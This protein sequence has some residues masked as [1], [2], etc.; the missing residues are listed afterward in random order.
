MKRIGAARAKD[1]SAGLHAATLCSDLELPWGSAAGVAERRRLLDRRIRSLPASAV[2]PF[3]RATAAGNGFVK[4]CLYWPARSRS[5][6]SRRAQPSS[7]A[8]ASPRG[9]PRPV[10]AAR[11]GTRGGAACATR[12]ARRGGRCGARSAEPCAERCRAPGGRGVP[13]RRHD[14]LSGPGRAL[15]GGRPGRTI[16]AMRGQMMDF[17][18]TLPHLLWRAETYWGDK[19]IVTRLPDKSFHRYTYRDMARRARQLGGCAPGAR[20]RTRRPRGDAVLEPPPAHGV[21]LRNPVRGLRAPHPQ[22]PPASERPRLHRE[23]RGRPGRD[24]RPQPPSAARAVSRRD[25]HRARARRRGLVRGAARRRVGR[26]LAR[27]RA[28][29][30][31]GGG[32]VLHERH[33]GEAEGRRLLAPLDGAAHVRA[34][35]TVNGLGLGSARGRRDPARRPDV[36]RERLGLPATW[37]RCSARS[38]SIRGRISTPRACWRTSSRRA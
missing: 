13:A 32:D 17:Q 34:S 24:R 14:G 10:H 36:P 20:P 7:G 33:D 9:Q 8:D 37:R 11:V 5:G 19:E 28:R 18:L 15:P 2:W 30:G 25:R 16:P 29:R 35:A 1:F 23:A 31:R 12:Q 26:R 22:R 4:T 38:S 6:R 27:P 21:L 3:D